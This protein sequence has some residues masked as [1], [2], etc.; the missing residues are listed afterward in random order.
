MFYNF[1]V[2]SLHHNQTNK[3]DMKHNKPQFKRSKKHPLGVN[4]T[5][6][7]AFNVVSVTVPNKSNKYINPEDMKLNRKYL[8][9]LVFG[10]Q[11]LGFCPTCVG[12]SG[13]S[14]TILRERLDTLFERLLKWMFDFSECLTS[15]RLRSQLLKSGWWR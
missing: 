15:E 8:I 5:V 14:V 13:H 3:T 4:N 7:I 2:L 9:F 12:F 11:N 1:I 6:Q 10:S